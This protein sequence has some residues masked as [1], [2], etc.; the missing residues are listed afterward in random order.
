MIV[1]KLWRSWWSWTD[2]PTWCPRQIP[3]MGFGFGEVRSF[4]TSATVAAQVCQCEKMMHQKVK[5]QDVNNFKDYW[6]KILRTTTW[7]LPGA[8]V[9]YDSSVVGIQYSIWILWP[10]FKETRERSTWGSPGPLLRK[11]ASCS[12]GLSW[13]F[14][15]TTC[16]RWWSI[17][18]AL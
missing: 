10:F 18:C 2:Q 5:D 7:G 14:H 3:K 16:G 13:L 6:K 1:T 4:F 9:Q 17:Y 15:G 11:K 8:K 12:S